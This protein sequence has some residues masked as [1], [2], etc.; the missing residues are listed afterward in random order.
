MQA[1]TGHVNPQSLCQRG[2]PQRPRTALPALSCQPCT[3]HASNQG[4]VCSLHRPCQGMCRPGLPCG[5]LGSPTGPSGTSVN[6]TMHP[7][8]GWQGWLS[9]CP[10]NIHG[11]AGH[12]AGP[13]QP[14]PSLCHPTRGSLHSSESPWLRVLHAARERRV[15][16]PCR[17]PARCQASE[18]LIPDAQL[19]SH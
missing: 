7:T 13:Q 4:R 9:K 11:L 16:N 1:S 12:G 15:C 19:S 18:V 6:G 10:H 5:E 3:G 17:D 8:W 2:R 14:G